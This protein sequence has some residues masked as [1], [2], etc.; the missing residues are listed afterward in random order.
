MF[1][2]GGE[3]NNKTSS[4]TDAIFE[5]SVNKNHDGSPAY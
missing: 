4:P 2:F 5:D 3:G 1:F